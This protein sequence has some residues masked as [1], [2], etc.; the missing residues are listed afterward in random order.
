[1]K[2]NLNNNVGPV[3]K[4]PHCGWEYVPSDIFLPEEH[5]GKTDTVIRD[6]L[7]KILYVEYD[8]D[9]EPEQSELYCCDHCNREFI[10]EVECKYKA[11]PQKEELD[12]TEL[13]SSLL[14]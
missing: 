13:S 1:M 12:F 8:E 3:I 5:I 4:C 6:A 7:G 9:N 2:L 14:D 11:T 10:V